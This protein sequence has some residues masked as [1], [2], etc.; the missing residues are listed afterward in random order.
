LRKLKAAIQS[1]PILGKG[2]YTIPDIA[3]ILRLPYHKVHRWINRF[4][5]EQLGRRYDSIYTWQIDLTKAVNFHTLVELFT[6]YRLSEA[7]VKS[8]KILD[9]HE[10]LSHQYKTSFPFATHKVLTGLRTDGKKILFEQK[11]GG[12]YSV[13]SSLQFKLSF[14]RDFLLNLD[15]DKDCLASRFWPIGKEK[16][17]V[18]DPHHQF[19]QPV[20][21]GTN[22]L[23][24]T[25]Y[26]MYKAD[27]PDK[28]IAALYDLTVKQVRNAIEFHKSFA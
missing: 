24:E 3:L 19:G 9:A 26:R 17:V 28:F 12:I 15:F 8:D 13:D 14:I 21:A 1:A 11:D 5:N 2:I 6:F 25:L 18:C 10:I 22:I 20:I 7:G 4:W 27:E 23:S 16:Q